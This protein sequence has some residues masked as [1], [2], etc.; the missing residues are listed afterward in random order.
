MTHTC[1]PMNVNVF[2]LIC[3]WNL[4]YI[5]TKVWLFLCPD[6]NPARPL[7]PTNWVSLSEIIWILNRDNLLRICYFALSCLSCFLVVNG[8]YDLKLQNT[9]QLSSS[10]STGS[11]TI[12]ELLSKCL[13]INMYFEGPL[14][15]SLPLQGSTITRLAMYV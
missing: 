11:G 14:V 4:F 1:S 10:S 12:F 2:L 3:K 7:L 15:R 13:R 6:G 8:F 5:L 9:T